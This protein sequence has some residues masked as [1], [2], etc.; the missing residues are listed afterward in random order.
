MYGK[1]FVGDVKDWKSKQ[2]CL[3]VYDVAT[4]N[5]CSSFRTVGIGLVPD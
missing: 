5:I 1:E 2:T 3:K 4:T